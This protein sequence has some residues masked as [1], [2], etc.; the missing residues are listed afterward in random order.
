VKYHLNSGGLLSFVFA[1]QFN[2][3]QGQV[4]KNAGVLVVRL[5][6]M[7]LTVVTGL[8]YIQDFCT[9]R[10]HYRCNVSRGL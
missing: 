8:L 3:K 4:L 6:I 2:K 1:M 5:Y 9:Y 10:T 7:T